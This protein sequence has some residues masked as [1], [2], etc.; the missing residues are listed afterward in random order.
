[1]FTNL[2]HSFASKVEYWIVEQSAPQI[3]RIWYIQHT[4]RQL[5]F[6]VQISSQNCLRRVQNLPQNGTVV[7]VIPHTD[8]LTDVTQEKTEEYFARSTP[9][10]W[11]TADK[12]K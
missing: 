10:M 4:L 2:Y 11:T 1:M 8:I 3:N 5:Y 7:G 6:H 9:V 12:E